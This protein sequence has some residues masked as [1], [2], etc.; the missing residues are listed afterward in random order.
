M[1]VEPLGTAPSQ[2][3]AIQSLYYSARFHL[4]DKRCELNRSMQHLLITW[5]DNTSR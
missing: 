1:T 4:S 2:P 5:S 3:L